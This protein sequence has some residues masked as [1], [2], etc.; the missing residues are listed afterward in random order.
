MYCIYTNN[1]L[2]TPYA[3]FLPLQLSKLQ[4]DAEDIKY[5]LTIY[6]VMQ[7]IK[8]GKI[9]VK[10]LFIKGVYFEESKYKT[11]L[12][13]FTF[14]LFPPELHVCAYIVLVPSVGNCNCLVNKKERKKTSNVAK[15]LTGGVFNYFNPL[16]FLICIKL[17]YGD[18]C[19][20]VEF[21]YSITAVPLFTDKK[22]EESTIVDLIHICIV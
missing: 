22:P 5:T 4:I 6:V 13:Y 3:F 17:H 10:M 19:L 9:T 12:G 11:F 1:H 15:F 14:L 8:T 18:H 20:F 21:L 16:F 2:K 7:L